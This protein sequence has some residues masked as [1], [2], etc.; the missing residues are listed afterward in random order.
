MP[1]DSL[2]PLRFA[3][4]FKTALWGGARLRTF[5]GA[6]PS[7]EPTGEAWLLSDQG[8]NPSV[9]SSGTFAGL[10]LRQL[11]QRWPERILGAASTV[12]G[13]FPILLKFIHA[14]EP[15]SV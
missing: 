2:T 15:L 10:T 9:V 5:L 3:P 8:D 14:R 13:R 12:Q 1:I 4:L 11:L 7:S 6:Q